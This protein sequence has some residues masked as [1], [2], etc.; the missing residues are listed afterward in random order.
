M[1]FITAINF[2]QC[3]PRMVKKAPSRQNNTAGCD[4]AE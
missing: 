2:H 3:L 1:G 4:M